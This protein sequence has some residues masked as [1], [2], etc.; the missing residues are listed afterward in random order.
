MDTHQS[1][2]PDDAWSWTLASLWLWVLLSLPDAW[3]PASWNLG[4]SRAFLLLKTPSHLLIFL[5]GLL[6]VVSVFGAN[7][8]LDE[9][10][11]HT[12]CGWQATSC[13]NF[14]LSTPGFLCSLT[15]A[16]TMQAWLGRTCYPCHSTFCACSFLVCLPFPFY[17]PI[18]NQRHPLRY[19]FYP[20]WPCSF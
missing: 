3:L 4:A 2:A 20:I 9:G 6:K 11:L 8:S 19:L 13:T 1:K 18:S 16:L 17:H 15:S 10:A 14:S 7:I 12:L 5:K